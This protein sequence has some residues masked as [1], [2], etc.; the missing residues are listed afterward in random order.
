MKRAIL[1]AMALIS[2]QAATVAHAEE[3]ALTVLLEGG[4]DANT[5]AIGLSADGKT[6]A[7]KSNATLEVGG[8]VCW[9]PGGAPTELLCEAP[10]I[11]GFEVNAGD[12]DDNVQVDP[13]VLIP[14]TLLGG[15]GNDTL[16]GGTGNDKLVGD[17]GRDRLDGGNGNDALFGGLGADVLMGEAGNDALTGEAG[18]D[19]LSGSAGRDLLAGNAGSDTLAGGNGADVLNG[20]A[21]PDQLFGGYGSDILVGGAID[22]IVGGPGRDTVQSRE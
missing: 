19:M 5:F 21:G 7:I 17:G 20:G 1:I 2:A 14:V 22:R 11:A 12:G 9:H 4:P 10:P 18:P 3:R 15:L 16:V 13:R 8:T 6:Y